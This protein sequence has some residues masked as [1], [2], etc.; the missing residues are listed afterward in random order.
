MESDTNTLKCPE[1]TW[2]NNHY[3]YI[4]NI[5][6]SMIKYFASKHLS[7]ISFVWVS[8]KHEIKKN[9]IFLDQIFRKKLIREGVNFATN[10]SYM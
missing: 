2:D 8:S 5:L 6:C 3:S 7:L 9:K 4:N 10:I 1:I